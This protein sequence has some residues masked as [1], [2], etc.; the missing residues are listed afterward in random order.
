MS[1]PDLLR[2]IGLSAVWGSSFLFLR[3][4]AP[5]FGPIPLILIRIG[6]AALCLSPFLLD[7]KVRA[8]IRN[9]LVRLFL[10]GIFNSAIPFCL[11]AFAALSLESGFSSLL[12]ATTPIFAALVGWIWMGN[13][14]RL[15]QVFGLLIGVLGVAI[16]VWGKLSFREGGLGWAI[17]AALLAGSSYGFAVHFTKRFLGHVSSPVATTGSLT[18]ASL[19]LLPLGLWYWPEANPGWLPWMSAFAL[20]AACTAF[21]YVVFFKII[22]TAGGTNASTVTF[23]VPGFAI[24]WGAV[25]L[26]EV[27]TL[28]I[29]AGM[30]VTLVGTGYATGIIGN[31]KKAV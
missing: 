13:S 6:G 8:G 5:A 19:L 30:V 27:I 11:L 17:A 21:A 24:L 14:L 9:N 16:L 23:I 10:L 20:A 31:R 26:D 1:T 22:A 28:R 7:R 12:N 4:A 18:G 15:G 25:F 29:L 3:I 2:L